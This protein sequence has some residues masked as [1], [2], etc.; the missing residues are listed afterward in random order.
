MG[1]VGLGVEGGDRFSMGAVTGVRFFASGVLGCLPSLRFLGEGVEGG[2]PAVCFLLADFSFLRGVVGGWESRLRDSVAMLSLLLG[3][4][5]EDGR[6]RVAVGGAIASSHV[7]GGGPKL[8]TPAGIQGMGVGITGLVARH[9]AI[10]VSGDIEYGLGA[11]KNMDLWSIR[12]GTG[13][14]GAWP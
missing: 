3:E 6:G 13:L 14:G 12:E 1:S 8:A 2:A 9:E 10:M 11:G 5:I 7:I 4:R